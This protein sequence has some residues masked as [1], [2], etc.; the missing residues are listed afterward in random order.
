MPCLLGADNAPLL[1]VQRCR[2]V[3]YCQ[4]GWTGGQSIHASPGSVQL[5]T[6]ERI[7]PLRYIKL[8]VQGT[9]PFVTLQQAAD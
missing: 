9:F 8:V 2:C 4:R 1:V 3:L 7:C 6:S 5:W